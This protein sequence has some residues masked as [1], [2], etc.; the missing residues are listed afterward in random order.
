MPIAFFHK[1]I[2]VYLFHKCYSVKFINNF[3]KNNIEVKNMEKAKQD[4][5]NGGEEFVFFNTRIP[6]SLV[7]RVKVYLASYFNKTGKRMTIG[8]FVANAIEE[9]LKNHPVE[10]GS[11]EQ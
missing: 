9:Y 6:L 3:N 10:A 5:G 1:H 11:N 8:E 2:H 7:K 4:E